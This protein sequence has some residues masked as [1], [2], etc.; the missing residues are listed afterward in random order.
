MLAHDRVL[1]TALCLGDM[2]DQFPEYKMEPLTD[3]TEPI[4]FRI[5]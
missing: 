1:N 2:I 4:Q 3:E 5:P